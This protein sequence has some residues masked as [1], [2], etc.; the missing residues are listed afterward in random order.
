MHISV[1][2]TWATACSWAGLFFWKIQHTLFIWL[3]FRIQYDNILTFYLNE[4]ARSSACSSDRDL[5]WTYFPNIYFSSGAVFCRLHPLTLYPVKVLLRMDMHESFS[6]CI[7][8]CEIQWHFRDDLD[9]ILHWRLGHLVV[10]KYLNLFCMEHNEN[11]I[12]VH[13]GTTTRSNKTKT[14][15]KKHKNIEWQ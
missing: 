11:Y 3:I 10:L 2:V 5:F 1:D 8:P 7:F 14:R 4:M 9:Y 12:R 6:M 13:L 15:T